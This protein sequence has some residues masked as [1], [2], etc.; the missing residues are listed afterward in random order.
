M[1]SRWYATPWRCSRRGKTSGMFRVHKRPVT[2]FSK[3]PLER[4]RTLLDG[5]AAA[6]RVKKTF[7]FLLEIWV[8]FVERAIQAVS[9]KRCLC[10]HQQKMSP[11]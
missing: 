7:V 6:P 1:S 11:L 9:Y 8:P 10:K 4:E 2:F 3:N 5:A